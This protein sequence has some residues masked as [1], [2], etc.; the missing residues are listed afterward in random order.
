MNMNEFKSNISKYIYYYNYIR[1]Y[2]KK[3]DPIKNKYCYSQYCLCNYTNKKPIKSL[4]CVDF[5]NR[6]NNCYA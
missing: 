3:I 6:N 4:R 5:L 1:E 2:K